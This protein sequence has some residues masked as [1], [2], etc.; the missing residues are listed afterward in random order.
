LQSGWG[1]TL[2]RFADDG[3]HDAIQIAP[4]IAVPK[5]KNTIAFARY[6][7][8]G[9]RIPRAIGFGSM[10]ATIELYSDTRSVFR[11]IEKISA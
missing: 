10:L 4:H 9:D 3:F 6:D 7:P 5:S 11:K 2:Q 8:I 1:T